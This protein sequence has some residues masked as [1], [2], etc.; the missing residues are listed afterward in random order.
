MFGMYAL[1]EP[2]IVEALRDGWHLPACDLMSRKLISAT[3]D[4][5]LDELSCLMVQ[6]NI[7]RVPIVRDGKLIGIVTREDVLRGMQ[8][9]SRARKIESYYKPATLVAA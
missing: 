3:E 7:N 4:A 9:A 1:P 6:K 5:T 2:E 8:P